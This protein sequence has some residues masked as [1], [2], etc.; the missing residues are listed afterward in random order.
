MIQNTPIT[1]GETTIFKL[2]DKET[3]IAAVFFCNN[4][5][6][7]SQRINV[8][9]Y[10]D[11]GTNAVGDAT[12]VVNDYDIPAGDTWIWD[13]NHKL[14]LGPNDKLSV[15]AENTGKIVATVSYMDITK[16]VV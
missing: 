14:I 8:Y 3:M 1:N 7:N 6:L 4:D 16:V 12:R 13:T 5:K 11:N 10:N 15:V 9:M 2:A